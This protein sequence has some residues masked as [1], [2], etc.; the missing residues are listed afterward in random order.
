RCHR[1]N[2]KTSIINGSEVS[3]LSVAIHLFAP[4]LANEDVRYKFTMKIDTKD[5]KARITFDDIHIYRPAHVTS[6]IAFPAIDSPNMT[7]GG[8]AKAKKALNDIVEQYKR[9]IVTES[10]SAAKDW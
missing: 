5:D 7:V 6:G 3:R 8:Q 4:S 2:M 9:E 10:S 1:Q